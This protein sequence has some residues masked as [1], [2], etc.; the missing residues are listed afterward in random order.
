[1]RKKTTLL[2]AGALGA[3]LLSSSA[4]AAA[5]VTIF[6]G[7]ELDRA[8]SKPTRPPTDA[9]ETV[10]IFP[11]GKNGWV[12][13]EI[14]GAYQPEDMHKGVKPV[15]G[16]RTN[17]VLFWA[18]WDGKLFPTYGHDP[19]EAMVK[20]VN[21]RT[22]EITFVRNHQPPAEGNKMVMVFSP[23]G[24]HLTATTASGTTMK[25]QRFEN[26]VRVYNWI[27]PATW[28]ARTP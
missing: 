18:T 3:S 6:G 28:P 12:W 9:A 7:W 23:D 26:D 10:M 19:R 21:D 4:W 11:W 27:D 20:K 24:K 25:G 8:A 22:F 14:S 16:P 17:R 13:T 1:M 2:I 5:A 15:E